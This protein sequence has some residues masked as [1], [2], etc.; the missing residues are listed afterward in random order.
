MENLE[1]PFRCNFLDFDLGLGFFRIQDGVLVGFGNL[2][3]F[4]GSEKETMERLSKQF[5]MDRLAISSMKDF[6]PSP[7]NNTDTESNFSGYKR[8]T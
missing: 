5:Y 2:E 8:E 7:F 3:G 4:I 6:T 1:A